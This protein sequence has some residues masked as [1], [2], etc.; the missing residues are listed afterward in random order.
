MHRCF[1]LFLLVFLFACGGQTPPA[2]SPPPIEEKPLLDP[3]L[4]GEISLEETLVERRSIRAYVDRPLSWEEI[5]QLLWAAQ[6]I[7]DP[8]GFRTAPSAGALF[9]LEMYLIVPEGWYR[10]RPKGHLLERLGD[11]D[12]REAIWAAGLEQDFLREAPAVFVI[13]AVVSRTEVKYGSRAERYVHLEA[14]HA[15]QNLLLQA[16]ALGL[17]AVPVG[18][19]HDDQLRRTLELPDSETPLYLIPVGEPFSP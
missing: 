17:G 19:F 5:S 13:T 9:P 2:E 18:A 6:G 1:I 3:R 12:L 4:L 14:G 16:T 11:H 8:R 7:T 15:A 10:Y